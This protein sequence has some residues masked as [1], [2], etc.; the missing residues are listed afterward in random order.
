METEPKKIGLRM[1]VGVFAAINK[2]N[3]KPTLKA[4]I[5]FEIDPVV[6][7]FRNNGIGEN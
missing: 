5:D 1:M 7:G 2:N 6:E 4:T 3:F